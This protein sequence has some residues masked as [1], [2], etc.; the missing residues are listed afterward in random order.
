MVAL[1][2]VR[3]V[4][5]IRSASESALELIRNHPGLIVLSIPG[6]VH[7]RDRASP[8]DRCE[9]V[10]RTHPFRVS[11]L[12]PVAMLELGPPSGIVPEPLPKASARAKISRPCIE[13]ELGLCPASGPNAV[14]QDTMAI[15]RLRFVVGPLKPEVRISHHVAACSEGGE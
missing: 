8:R 11:E 6:A 7:D 3:S 9:V 4:F 1:V 5:S 15:V 2:C 13:S 12:L 10:E 14:D